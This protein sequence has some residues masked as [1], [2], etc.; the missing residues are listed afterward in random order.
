MFPFSLPHS[1]LCLTG[2]SVMREFWEIIVSLGGRLVESNSQGR[3]S[4]CG[5]RHLMRNVSGDRREPRLLPHAVILSQDARASASAATQASWIPDPF[6][7]PLPC[8]NS[9]NQHLL[10]EPTLPYSLGFWW[11]CRSENPVLLSIGIKL[12]VTQARPA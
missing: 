2:H 12:Y 6:P 1:P 4:R 11:G 10:W 9:M 7:I 8:G 5:G 3:S